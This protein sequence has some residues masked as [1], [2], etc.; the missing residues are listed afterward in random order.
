[1][2]STPSHI[3]RGATAEAAAARLLVV[4]VNYRTPDLT[5]DCLRSLAPEIGA[6]PGARVVVVDNCSGDGSPARLAEA[7]GRQGWASWARLVVTERNGGFSYGNNRG[8]EAGGPAEYVLLLNSDTVVHPGCLRYCLGVMDRDP[9]IGALGCRLVEPDGQPQNGAR[10][11]PSPARMVLAGTGL[12]WRHPRLFGWADT[13]D[14]GWDRNTIKRDADWLCGAF[15]MLRGSVLERIGGLD[16]EFFFYGEDIE[17]CHRVWRS[18]FRCHYDPGATVTH[19]G[20]ASSDP[21]RMATRARSVHAWRARYLV[22]LKCYGWL[23]FAAVRCA[24]LLAYG[25]RAALLWLSGRGSEPRYAEM[26][27]IFR[28]LSR[29]LEPTP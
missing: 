25:V 3:S 23:G 6:C 17:F 1:M 15:I 10:R 12:P 19:L 5:I 27:E 24:D 2:V 4:I 13:E 26:R 16:E 21:T 20:G 22:Q 7:I 18:G 8:F 14:P 11:F 29:R 28:L 9:T